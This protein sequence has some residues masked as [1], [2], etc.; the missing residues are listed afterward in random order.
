MSMPVF[1]DID[2]PIP[3]EDALSMILVSIAMEEIGLSHVINAEGE[4]IQYALRE[5]ASIEETIAVNNSVRELIDSVAYSQC[6]LKEKVKSVAALVKKE[7]GPPGPTGPPGN[8][9]VKGNKGD[10]G[11]KGEK[12]NKGDKGDKGDKGE[13]GERGERGPAGRANTCCVIAC[14][15]RAGQKWRAGEP[16]QWIPSENDDCCSAYLSCDGRQI[17]LRSGRCFLV[18]FTVNIRALHGERQPAAVC[19]RTMQGGRPEEH[20]TCH[21][22]VSCGNGPVTLSAA[23]L[24]L[25]VGPDGYPAGEYAKLSLT[26]ASPDTVEATQASICVMEI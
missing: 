23:G 9:G 5:N 22:S 17:L 24:Y 15:G 19:V 26:L 14:K 11:E 7:P 8:P 21:A 13:R 18:H 3:I 2:P 10:K 12:G 4:K 6:I 1:P 16:L 25:P 20:Y